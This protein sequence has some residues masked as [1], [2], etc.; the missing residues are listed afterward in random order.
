MPSKPRVLKAPKKAVN[1]PRPKPAPAVVLPSF[2]ETKASTPAP[3]SEP[4]QDPRTP[5]QALADGLSTKVGGDFQERFLPILMAIGWLM[6]GGLLV[7]D[8]IPAVRLDFAMTF[9]G[10]LGYA[11][12]VHNRHAGRL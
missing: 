4:V 8:V 9:W 12:G 2:E 1:L 7:T 5:L 10:L 6:L 3:P 11:A